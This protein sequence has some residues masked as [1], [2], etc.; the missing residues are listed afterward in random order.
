[1]LGGELRHE[2]GRQ[3]RGVRERLV[4]G[5]REL[6]Q[7]LDRVGTHDELVVVG[8]YCS[9]TSRACSSSSKERSSKPIENVLI[10]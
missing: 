3:G 8:Q 5:L 9:A 1:M 10:R 6:R 7:E 2:V 4:E